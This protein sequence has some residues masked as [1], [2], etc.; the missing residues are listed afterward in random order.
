[1]TRFDTFVVTGGLGGVMAA[2]ARGATRAGGVAIGV[3]PGDASG[4][5]HSPHTYTIATGMGE[6]RNAIVVNSADV[7]VAIGHSW[8][9]VSEIALARRAGKQV[10][11]IDGSQQAEAGLTTWS[12]ESSEQLDALVEPVIARL[13][14]I[15]RPRS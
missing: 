4:G 14:E 8:G 11:Q 10:L 13:G 3:I 12:S 1:M 2:A 15:L 6:A 7:V 5:A 9:T